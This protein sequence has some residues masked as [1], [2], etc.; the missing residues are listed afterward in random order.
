MRARSECGWE[1]RFVGGRGG[2]GVEEGL[3]LI[4][5]GA[6]R[7][8]GGGRTDDEGFACGEGV[9]RSIG[10]SV[11]GIAWSTSGGVAETDAGGC[12]ADRK[13]VV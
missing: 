6:D 10:G 13:S 3:R 4:D 9:S 1:G 2:L 8:S 11:E 5:G 12:K 7:G